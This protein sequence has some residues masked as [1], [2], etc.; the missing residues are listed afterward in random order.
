MTL[1]VP[2][3]VSIR[4][5]MFGGLSLVLLALTAFRL[6]MIYRAGIGGEWC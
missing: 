3:V 2:V 6:L 1:P 5:W 4:S